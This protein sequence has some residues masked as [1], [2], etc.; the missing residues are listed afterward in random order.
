MHEDASQLSSEATFAN[1]FWGTD[2]SGI[3]VI[4]DKLRSSKQTCDELRRIYDTRSQI[5]EEYGEKLL[6]LSQQTLGSVEQGTFSESLSQ[7]PSAM[8]ATA[9]AHLDLSEKLKKF[10]EFPL[11]GF[12]KDQK[13]TR[14]ANLSHV[15]K[16]RQLK[17]LH[18]ANVAKA[19]EIYEEE[20]KKYVDMQ[21]SFNE[22][23]SSM[24]PAEVEK[25]KKQ[26]K[27]VQDLMGM[28]EQDY[29]RATSVLSSISNK[30]IEDHK[31][32]C[33][34]FQTMEEDRLN[35]LRSSLFAYANLLSSVFIINDQASEKI[36]SALES[37]DVDRDIDTFVNSKSTGQQVPEHVKFENY[38]DTNAEATA[39]LNQ[40]E[41]LEQQFQKEE[42]ERQKAAEEQRQ[43][44]ADE[45]ELRTASLRQASEVSVPTIATGAAV[46]AAATAVAKG[47]SRSSME[48]FN[49]NSR[50]QEELPMDDYELKSHHEAIATAL[51]Q[52]ETMLDDVTSPTKETRPLL[53][54]SATSPASDRH[55]AIMSPSMRDESVNRA[56][57][58]DSF[59]KQRSSDWFGTPYD[60]QQNYSQGQQPQISPA[61][62]YT[63]D[64]RHS[65]LPMINPQYLHT[66]ERSEHSTSRSSLEQQQQ[67][68]NG[69]N[70]PS[71]TDEPSQKLNENYTQPP[72]N[73]KYED[74]G[75]DSDDNQPVKDA[76]RPPPKDEK[77]VISSIR[78]PQQVPVR[79]Q[80]AK[81]YE[82]VSSPVSEP[83]S[84]DQTF[85]TSGYSEQP[86]LR[87]N[88]T[89]HM[90]DVNDI[91]E[92]VY[93]GEP[94]A[95]SHRHSKQ[96]PNLKIA[97]PAGQKRE[98]VNDPK[99]VAGNNIDNNDIVNNG[100][101]QLH[102]ASPEPDTTNVA[103][104]SMMRMFGRENNISTG[105]QQQQQQQYPS[106]GSMPPPQSMHD[107]NNNQQGRMEGQTMGIRAPPWQQQS[108]RQ[109]GHQQNGNEQPMSQY[110]TSYPSENVEQQNGK[111]QNNVGRMNSVSGP[112]M[113]NQNLS[114]GS[115]LPPSELLSMKLAA[116]SQQQERQ[117]WGGPENMNGRGN[118]YG[119]NNGYSYNDELDANMSSGKP[120]KMG[121]LDKMKIALRNPADP[122]W[123]DNV[124]P[125]MADKANQRSS[126]PA[127]KA[128]SNKEG[129]GGRFS[130]A[131]FGKKDKESKKHKEE[132]EQYPISGSS[133]LG[134]VGGNQFA[135]NNPRQD[136]LSYPTNNHTFSS[137]SDM[138]S[139]SVN[140][141]SWQREQHHH[142]QQQQ[143]QRE[144]YSDVSDPPRTSQ[145]L[146]QKSSLPPT[147]AKGGAK[148]LEDGTPVVEYA[149]ALWSY[150][151]KIP[152]ELS[153]QAGDV[154]AIINKQD[155]GWWEAQSMAYPNLQRALIPGNF[156]Q[157]IA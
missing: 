87:Q 95:F 141:P 134:R 64:T 84:F 86:E 124:S 9:R 140:S 60:S 105:P 120:N 132:R 41:L 91:D 148:E 49:H 59:V 81:M 151:A 93:N 102:L 13:E 57:I 125:N 36:R 75:E 106:Q 114:K 62:S 47:E 121:P 56:P 98:S 112:R 48:S 78:R 83:T 26:I 103:R 18:M 97:I 99:A 67:Y 24:T 116:P 14:K 8:E 88:S 38:F 146:S 55:S 127:E 17:E 5:E 77:W 152:T 27:D 130:L 15:E 107:M 76:P 34:V 100:R 25:T 30:W 66:Q 133:S 136:S 92:P 149:R 40:A 58:A 101:N 71:V 89:S 154:M 39:V 70:G 21:K 46:T 29:K 20:C 6:K 7:I 19:K 73:T 69:D 37:T 43:R 129:K 142:H 82:S 16:S 32:T 61:H 111:P 52:V 80:N 113:P 68:I 156:F 155:D 72:A 128:S 45:E 115:Q 50:Q 51:H 157:S 139:P 145:S 144:Q 4:A 90:R 119:P 117:D 28:A 85:S 35:Y 65:F 137:M 33:N 11:T 10:L 143:Q 63:S 147:S 74:E 122:R 110:L 126:L 138:N 118:M 54:A 153:F 12:V 150:S 123:S 53:G 1:N 131:I 42:E 104:D 94:D 3:D 109:N 135:M 108:D 44:D 31:T 22:T 23:R 79:A 96:Q 2:D